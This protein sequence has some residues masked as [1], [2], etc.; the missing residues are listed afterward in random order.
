MTNSFLGDGMLSLSIPGPSR[1]P[2]YY[3]FDGNSVLLV[4]ST[5]FRV[6]RSTL[7]KDRS[8]FETMFQL[9]SETD[10]SRSESSVTIA[11]EG[12]SDDNPIRLQ[13]DTADEFRALLWALY[14]LPHELLIAM[15]PEANS[16]QLV[17]LARITNKYQFRS[18]E[19]WALG[20]LNSYY[21]RSGA[22]DDVP[23]THPP[24]L[25]LGPLPAHGAG[26]PP[27]QPSLTQLTEL[28]ALCER[29]DLLDAIVAR[30]KRLIGEGKDLAQA[31][32]VGERFNLRGVLG[33]AYHAMMLKG[34][35][36]WD[37]DAYLSREQ[38]V[39]LL[40]G[41]YA[42]N[43]LSDALPANPPVL[44][45]TARCTSQQRCVK[46]FA[47]VWKMILETGTQMI[48]FQREDVL[49]RILFAEGVMKALVKDEIPSQGTMDGM[50][51]C[52]EN[53]LFAVSMKFR[54]IK[55]SLA[56]YFT[57]EF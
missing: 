52:K 22:F 12:E 5:L 55:D 33:L 1:D 53:A 17:A 25:P 51:Q 49:G 4:E 14:A 34:K 19:Q 57:D 2:T 24:S 26:A 43:K 3:I 50:Q 56:D 36:A 54:E 10:S 37:A 47:G 42:L 28:A 32:C 7:T 44:T 21:T 39:R 18:L 41:Y 46:A 27:P 30:W 6:H 9:S 45:H 38:R 15:T 20:A 29:F 11:M 23:T 31:I 8:A 16:A 48:P 13:G 35:T 40:C